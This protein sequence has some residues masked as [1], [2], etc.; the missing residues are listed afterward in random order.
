VLVPEE[1]E[2][3]FVEDM[4]SREPASFR[5]GGPEILLFPT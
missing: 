2:K 3:R 5:I 1:F 4:V